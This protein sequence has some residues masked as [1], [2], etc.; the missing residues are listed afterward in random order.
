[1]ELK[2]YYMVS[3]APEPPDRWITSKSTLLL[4]NNNVDTLRSHLSEAVSWIL[5]NIC[6]NLETLRETSVN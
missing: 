5:I 3:Y 4:F 6:S 2:L 1:M